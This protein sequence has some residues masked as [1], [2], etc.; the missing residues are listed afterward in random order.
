MPKLFYASPRDLPTTNPWPGAKGR[1]L[2]TDNATLIVFDLDA[3]IVVETHKHDV[4][5]LG[6]VVKGSL[7]MVIAGEQRILTPGDTYRIP[8]GTAHGA[9]VF[10]EPTQ[11]IDVYAPPRKD[12]VIT[13]AN[14]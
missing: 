13:P 4:E 12:L 5:Q 6:I 9:R 14:P 7:A 1:V 3:K 10:E 8:A 11:V 2:Q